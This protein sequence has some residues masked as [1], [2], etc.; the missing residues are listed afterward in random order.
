M[1]SLVDACLPKGVPPPSSELSSSIHRGLKGSQQG[2]D[3]GSGIK[4]NYL[5]LLRDKNR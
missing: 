1:A 2:S 5:V 3:L 4:V